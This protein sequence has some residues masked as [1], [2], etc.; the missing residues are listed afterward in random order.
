MHGSHTFALLYLTWLSIWGCPDTVLTDRRTEAENDAFINA[1]HSMGVHWRPIPTKA[2][3]GI[4]RNECHRGPIRDAYI[5]ITAESPALAPELAIAM[6]YKARNGAPRAHGSSP[7]AAVTGAAPCLLIGDSQ[8]TDPTIA[9]R[10]HAMQS[11]RAT[12]ETYTAADR[13]CGAL[14]HPVT[15][16]PFV[17]VNQA[18]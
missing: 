14:F 16:V 17:E 5:R 6:A 7:T 10:H 2:P 18:V 13:L 4:G 9:A 15:S 12:M 11:A 8:H 1:L 3:W